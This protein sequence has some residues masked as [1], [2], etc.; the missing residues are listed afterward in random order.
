MKLRNCGRLRHYPLSGVWVRAIEL[1]YLD[2][3]LS[4][5]HTRLS[6]SR[7]G[8]ASPSDPS[9]RILYLAENHQTALYEVGALMGPPTAPI[10]DPK[11]SWLLLSLDVRLGRVIDLCDEEQRAIVGT[12]FQ[13]LTGNWAK[14]PTPPPTQALG[15]AL[16]RLPKLEGCLFPSSKPSGGRILL[17]FPDKLD[18]KRSSIVFRNDLSRELERLT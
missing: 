10:A 11:V 13:E 2:S 15:N 16:Y 17:V 5:E 14:S 1:I 6:A 7:F 3:R 12:T 9:Y 8:A 4:T 18:I